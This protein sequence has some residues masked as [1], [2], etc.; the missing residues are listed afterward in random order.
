MTE[1]N[2]QVENNIEFE[3]AITQLMGP[4]RAFASIIAENNSEEGAVLDP[5]LMSMYDGILEEI[6]KHN[7]APK[8]G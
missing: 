5:L 1:N 4:V 6:N 2:A 7:H 3:R 8:E